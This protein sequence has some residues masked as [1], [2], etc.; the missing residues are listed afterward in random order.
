MEVTSNRIHLTM[1]DIQDRVIEDIQNRSY[2]SD[3]RISQTQLKHILSSL[4]NYFSKE[5]CTHFALS[6]DYFSKEKCNR[7][8]YIFLI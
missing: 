7:L 2:R 4:F 5:K 3:P 8:S 6:F 1:I